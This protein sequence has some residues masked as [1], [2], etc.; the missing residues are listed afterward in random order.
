MTSQTPATAPVI[1]EGGQYVRRADGQLYRVLAVLTAPLPVVT[2]RSLVLVGGRQQTRG[3][4]RCSNLRAFQAQYDAW[5][6]AGDDG[7][8]GEVPA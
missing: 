7:N 6:P 3:L 5:Q 8:V 1:V 4:L 2:F